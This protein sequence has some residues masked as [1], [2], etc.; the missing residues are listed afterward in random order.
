MHAPSPA[1][2]A[3]RAVV[4]I[5]VIIALLFGF[6][7]IK[8]KQ[9]LGDLVRESRTLASD[10]SFFQQFYQDDA[11]KTLVRAIGLI[12]AANE[13]GMPPDIFIDRTLGFEA[14]FFDSGRE[15]EESPRQL[16]VRRTLAANYDHFLKLGYQADF[17]TLADMREG[18]LPPIM[19]GPSAGKTP[20]ITTIIDPALA[21]GLEKVVANYQIRPPLAE[22]ENSGPDEVETAV[23]K[24]LAND[25]AHAG[26]IE[27]AARDRIQQELSKPAAADTR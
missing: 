11:R 1:T 16:L 18:V 2:I 10:S 23:A 6:G 15:R 25:L 12:A 3:V 8:K 27:P 20:V 14:E 13:L 26:V 5:G 22:G 7:F 17:R 24:Q 4:I 21:P 9:R 19:A